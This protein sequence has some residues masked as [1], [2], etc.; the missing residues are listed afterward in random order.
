MMTAGWNTPDTWTGQSFP[1][2]I[3]LYKDKAH[4]CGG[5]GLI[6]PSLL[7]DDDILENVDLLIDSLCQGN[8][9]PSIPSP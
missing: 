3:W 5:Q 2:Y 8:S 9:A 1:I 7:N 6:L 4:G